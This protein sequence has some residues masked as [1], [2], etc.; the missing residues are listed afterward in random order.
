VVE[1]TTY[2]QKLQKTNN[3]QIRKTTNN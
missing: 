1:K 3:I 2:K